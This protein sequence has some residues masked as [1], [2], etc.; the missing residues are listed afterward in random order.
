MKKI[1]YYI[2]KRFGFYLLGFGC[3]LGAVILDMISPLLTKSIL[4]DVI[5]KGEIERLVPILIAILAI[6]LGSALLLYFRDFI[7][8][9]NGSKITMSLRLSLYKHLQR[10]SASFYDRYNTGELM[11]RV[12]D[13]IDRVGDA[14]TY[15]VMLIIEVVLHVG[16][17][18]FFMFRLDPLLT[19]LPLVTMFLCGF[20]AIYME[21]KLDSLYGEISEENAVLT[22]IAQENLAGVRTV[23]AFAREKFELKKFLSH[24]ERYCEL[25]IKQSK[26]FARYQPLFH[27]ITG[28]LPLLVLILGGYLVCQGK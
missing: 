3:L 28:L 6:G 27:L 10:L 14:L 12:K 17:I 24:N 26:V 22:T 18:L 25:N 21:R 2:R 19:L 23:K 13:D 20:G 9:V 5:G 7:F 8:D 1:S 16:L 11:A 4:D 15:V